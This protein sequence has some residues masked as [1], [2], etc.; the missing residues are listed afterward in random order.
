[1]NWLRENIGFLLF[2][3]ICLISCKQNPVDA[4]Y[5][6]NWVNT[7]SYEYNYESGATSTISEEEWPTQ[8]DQIPP[9]I[10]LLDHRKYKKYQ[11]TTS[12]ASF[13]IDNGKW[14]T[15]NNNDLT[16]QTDRYLFSGEI[17]L[18][19]ESLSI[20]GIQYPIDKNQLV[21]REKAVE[22]KMKYR[23]ATKKE[24]ALIKSLE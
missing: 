7:Y 18:L 14:S 5:Y 24:M 12:G 8:R 21:I 20:E 2:I 10:Q 13:I 23:R 1:M 9:I 15:R 11:I 4:V 19:N 6:G 17:I 16:I 22:Y 3:S